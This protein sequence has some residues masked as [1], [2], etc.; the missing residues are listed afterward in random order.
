[1]EKEINYLIGNLENSGLELSNQNPFEIFSNITIDFLSEISNYL[2]KIPEVRN[3]PDVATFA[4]YCRRANINTLKK[5]YSNEN[6]LR[7][8]RGIVFHI[9]PG[10]VPVNFAY[11]LLAGLVT[12]N[13][14]IVKVPSKPFEQVNIIIRAFQEVLNISLKIQA[15]LFQLEREGYLVENENILPENLLV[16]CEHLNIQ[17]KL[18]NDRL[19]ATKIAVKSFDCLGAEALIHHLK[20]LN[21]QLVTETDSPDLTIILIDDYLNPNLKE[22]NQKALQSQTSWLLVKPVGTIFWM[23]PFFEAQKTACWQ[24]LAHRLQ[25][26]RPMASFI[27]F[28]DSCTGWTNI[29]LDRPQCG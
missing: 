10:N 16:F 19:K 22:F 1:M 28:E 21:I 17:P 25:D 5:N 26:N 18:A 27:H 7:V 2:L 11:S 4:F 12:G 6:L 8:G 13:I 3:Y 24:C 9:A 15:A 14:N 23:G 29:G 20:L